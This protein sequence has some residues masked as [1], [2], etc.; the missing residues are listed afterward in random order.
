MIRFFI[1]ATLSLL[2]LTGCKKERETIIPPGSTGIPRATVF[3][4]KKVDGVWKLY[5]GESE[6]YINGA[7]TNNFYADVKDWGGN[8]VRTYGTNEGTKAILDEAWSKR[9]YVNMGLAMKDSDSFDYSSASNATA[10]AEQFENH[11]TWVRRFRNH[12]AVLCWSIGNEAET[13]DATKNK[14]YF[15]EVE[16]IAAMI[17]E[18]DP[19]HPTTVTFSNSD[20][21]N[22]IK[23][24][25]QNAPSIDILSINMY[26]PS[27]GKVAKTSLG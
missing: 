8:V 6:F 11:R 3:S 19:N 2:T 18:E 10:I 15:K 17:H 12:P 4:T 5:K 1:I 24:L 14:V 7:A 27:V 13:G 22:R 26:Y 23:I 9:L 25:M 21:N 16:K 20:V